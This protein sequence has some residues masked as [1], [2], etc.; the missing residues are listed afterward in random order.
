MANPI[1]GVPYNVEVS[2][3]AWGLSIGNVFIPIQNI[4]VD[5]LVGKLF[6]LFDGIDGLQMSFN[7]EK[8]SQIIAYFVDYGFLTPLKYSFHLYSSTL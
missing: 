5:M 2:E 8:I 1:K 4:T 6:K 7:S 3:S